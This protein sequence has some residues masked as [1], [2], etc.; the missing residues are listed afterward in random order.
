MS[1][2]LDAPAGKYGFLQVTPDGH[3]RFENKSETERF[4]GVVN[5][6]IANFPTREQAPVLAARMAKFGI[7]L[8]RIHLMDV[9][10]QYGLF[11]NSAQN[12]LQL[13]ASKL[14]KMDYFIK[15]L[16]DKGIYF[17][18]CIHS[19]RMYKTGDG[20]DAPVTNNQSKY[21][22]L[23]NQK[24]I[25]LQKDFATKTIGHKNPYTNLTYADDPAMANLELTN[26][27]SLFNGWLGWQSD[28]IF[29]G[30]TDGI[31]TYYSRELDTMFNN[32]LAEKYENDTALREAWSGSAGEPSAE[33]I[34]NNSFEQNLTSWG[35]L[36][37][38]G[39]QGKISIDT[40]N[41]KDGSKSIKIVVTSPGTENWNVQLMTNDFKVEKNKSYK[42]S[43]YTKAD[44]EKEV[45]LE[46]MER[47]TWKWIMGPTYKTT[48]DWKLQEVYFNS[49]FDSQALVVALEWGL[50]TGTFWIDSVSVTE[51]FGTGLEPG[52]SLPAKNIKRTKNSEIGKYSKQ[53]VG[54]NAEFYF[55]VEKNYTDE[56]SGFLKNDLNVKC[57]VTFTNNYFGLAS[58]YSQ[59]QADYM[60]FH[61]YWDHPNYP[62]GWSNTDFTMQNKSMLLNPQGS[63][64]NHMLLSKVKNMPLVLSEYNHPY[65]YIFQSEAPSLLY[66]YGSFFDLDGILWHAYYD[67]MNNFSQRQQDMFFDIAMH[68]VMMTQM[69]LA[70]PYRMKSIAAAKTN[71]EANYRE[72]DVFNNTKIYQ[73][74][75]LINLENAEY[76]T[77]FL[78]HGFEHASFDADSSFLKGTLSRP[79]NIIT[80]DTGELMWNG[81]DG[82]FTVNNPFWQGATGYLGNKTIELENI[83]ISNVETTDNL[84]FAAIHLISLDSLPIVES[85]RMLLL[86]S[87]RLENQGLQWNADKTRLIS[88]GGSRAL[89]EP[90]KAMIKFKGAS[91][92]SLMVYK[93]DVRGA[94]ADS[95]LMDQ[96]GDD[97]RFMPDEK[98]LWYEISNHRFHDIPQG[99]NSPGK[100]INGSMKIH[101]NPGR[102]YSNIEFSFPEN[103]VAEF[104]LYNSTGCL[105]QNE[106]V[107]IIPNRINT[108]RI[109]LNELN[110]GIYFYGFHFQD[111]MKIMDKLVVNN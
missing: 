24:I 84:N 89:C 52:E 35:N 13:S 61:M 53:R 71:I 73:D 17:N 59:S 39:A 46:V 90:V 80:S 95:L 56:L 26:E 10:G 93:L 86:T 22:T 18:F 62:N 27:N 57:P 74:N 68:P 3:F 44:V 78:Q 67:Y 5:V 51:T 83:T 38:G 20:I 85:K 54:D 30:I 96:S 25:G 111:G 41:A 15:C 77:S 87:A 14:D 33:L 36:V 4:V 106:T 76:G 1:A 110:A 104:V 75:D 31:G 21:V 107:R 108:K 40:Q 88:A 6:A 91:S 45:R 28:F 23:F 42:I 69:M 7:N 48:T 100:N 58:I 105:I 64:I 66:A 55:D 81:N 65:P 47:Q 63:T 102:G 109:D 101:P 99:S 92:D 49:P 70:L 43:F 37:T 16:K 29:E 98:T 82:Y 50:Q 8:V 72:Q 32:W 94:R 2:Y 19:G 79:G 34:K 60:D 103:S 97:I 11:Q 9:E 12:T